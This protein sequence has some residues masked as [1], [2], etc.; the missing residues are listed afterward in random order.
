MYRAKT[1]INKIIQIPF[2]FFFESY[3]VCIRCSHL[4]LK[5]WIQSTSNNNWKNYIYIGVRFERTCL[6]RDNALATG[7]FGLQNKNPNVK[8]FKRV[9]F[10]PFSEFS[11]DWSLCVSRSKNRFPL[12]FRRQ[13]RRAVTPAPR[14]HG[15]RHNH[16]GTYT[17]AHTHPD[18]RKK[19]KTGRK[20][21]QMYHT[22]DARA[23]VYIV[24]AFKYV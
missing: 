3:V 12:S 8:C 14:P 21:I 24:H 5:H 13:C 20:R 23:P 22:N 7:A 1:E 19:S 2:E 10:R 15:P 11:L 6:C 4:T 18:G 16:A 9:F 17:G